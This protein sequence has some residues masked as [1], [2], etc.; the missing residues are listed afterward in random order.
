MTD[1]T[2]QQTVAR[3]VRQAYDAWALEHP[4]LAEVIDRITLQDR[5]VE[6][7]RDTEEYRQAV[8]SYQRGMTE[9]DLLNRLMELVSPILAAV[10]AG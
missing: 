10:L 5:V 1:D 7:L 2:V 3:S 6:L 8:A 4:S 9:T